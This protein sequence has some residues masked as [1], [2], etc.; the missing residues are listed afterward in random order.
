MLLL[1][2]IETVSVLFGGGLFHHLDA[3][4]FDGEAQ[5]DGFLG[6]LHLG[7]VPLFILLI[8]FL[9][10]FGVVGLLVQ[11]LTKSIA[12][13]YWPA[14]LAVLPALVVSLPAVRGFGALFARLV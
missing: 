3:S 8:V 12:G 11:A 13:F 7:R 4:M 14:A 10:S 5:I 1:I 2:A 9:T 6:W